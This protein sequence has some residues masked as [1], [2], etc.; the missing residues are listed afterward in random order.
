M[1][2]IAASLNSIGF[3]A[4]TLS[5]SPLLQGCEL[6]VPFDIEPRAGWTSRDASQA[7]R[8]VG[9]GMRPKGVHC[10]L[11]VEWKPPNLK[12]E[13]K[14]RFGREGG[15]ET[16]MEANLADRCR[17]KLGGELNFTKGRWQGSAV[18]NPRQ[19]P[20]RDPST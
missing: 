7:G 12:I 18:L 3:P 1:L 17:K 16:E 15:N 13:R 19:S 2:R 11:K 14:R 10:S 5:F 4:V 6:S 20:V 8:R 9:C